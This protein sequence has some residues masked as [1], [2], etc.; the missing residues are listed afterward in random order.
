M[1]AKHRHVDEWAKQGGIDGTLVCALCDSTPI[2]FKERFSHLS[3]LASCMMG[4]K[5][6]TLI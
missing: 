5:L 4:A 6:V 1:E 2:T 3:R